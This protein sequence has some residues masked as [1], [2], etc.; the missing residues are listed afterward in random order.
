M[1]VDFVDRDF[2]D[3]Y[4]AAR[5]E[6]VLAVCNADPEACRTMADYERLWMKAHN[7]ALLARNQQTQTELA[8][9]AEQTK[10]ARR[11]AIRRRQAKIDAQQQQCRIVAEE[12]ARAAQR[13]RA[14][15]VKREQAEQERL[16][17]AREQRRRIGA[18]IAAGT[19]AYADAMTRPQYTSA[20]DPE[21]YTPPATVSDPPGCSSDYEC[22]I[23]NRCVKPAGQFNGYCARTVNAYGTPVQNMPDPKSIGPGQ[24]R[25]RFM[26]DCPIGF[27]C[28]DGQCVKP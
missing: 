21:P 18:A 1:Y 15:R 24:R 22:G 17:E 20:P 13:E 4:T 14:E 19:K 9:R 5:P 28:D 12:L 26:T 2:R 3:R 16:W 10:A 25:C 8:A 23:G 27:Q 6:D 11:E 7:V